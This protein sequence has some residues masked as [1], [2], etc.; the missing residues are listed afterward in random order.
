[1]YSSKI[2]E[3]YLDE[4]FSKELINQVKIPFSWKLLIV[5]FVVLVL[6]L[7]G[8]T[9]YMYGS[10]T[11]LKTLEWD[12]LNPDRLIWVSNVHTFDLFLI[13]FFGYPTV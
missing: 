1:M 4:E 7:K 11:E 5:S 9:G 12:I 3:K 10:W 6:T 2:V 13:L 8:V